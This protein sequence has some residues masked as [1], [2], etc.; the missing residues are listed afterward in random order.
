MKGRRIYKNQ[1][2]RQAREVEL[3][4]AITAEISQ[5]S[6]LTGILDHSLQKALWLIGVDRGGIYLLD[7]RS[8][9]LKITAH[10]GLTAAFV[11]QIDGLKMGEGFSGQVAQTG[12]PLVIQDIAKDP[13]LTRL[14]VIEAGIRSVAVVPI[15]TKGKILGTLFAITSGYRKFF[16]R[17]V[18][19]L[20]SIGSQV[21]VAIENARLLVDMQNRLAQLAALQETSRAV[22]ST[23]DRNALLELIIQQATTL[24]QAEGGMLNLVNWEERGDEVVACTGSAAGT[25]GIRIPLEQSLSGWVTLHNQPQISNRVVEDPRTYQQGGMDLFQKRLTNAAVAPMSVK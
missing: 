3:L 21:G 22:V 24:L 9:L 10:C 13:R 12:G 16:Q 23:L 15:R 4:N 5:S 2:V 7:E 25:V 1:V 17:E 20:T 18:D 6:D 19:L 11:E 14:A 8:S